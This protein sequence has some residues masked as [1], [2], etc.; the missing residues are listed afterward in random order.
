MLEVGASKDLASE[1]DVALNEVM[2][3]LRVE[4]AGRRIRLAELAELR[5]NQIIDLE[6]AATDPVELIVGDRVVA[7]GELIDI[8]GRLGVRILQ[9]LR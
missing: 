1:F 9:V 2:L 4:L 6:R 8:E 7:R 5:T 3:T